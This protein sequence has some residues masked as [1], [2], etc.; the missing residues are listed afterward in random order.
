M[1]PKKLTCCQFFVF[2]DLAFF[3]TVQGL[4]LIFNVFKKATL[5]TPISHLLIFNVS[6]K[7]GLRYS[8]NFESQKCVKNNHIPLW[9]YPI[10]NASFFFL[11][12]LNSYSDCVAKFNG[13]LHLWPKC[14]ENLLQMAVNWKIIQLTTFLK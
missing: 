1:K 12:S 13:I 7:F 11:E 3:P 2:E 10:L 6:T 14:V 8:W 4:G 9:K 5:K